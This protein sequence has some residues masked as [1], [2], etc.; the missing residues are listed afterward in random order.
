MT[1]ARSNATAPAAKGQ[2]VVGTGTDTSGVLSVGSNDQVL[3]A[4]SSTS[5]GVKWATASSGGMTV[6]GTTSLSGSSTTI[7]SIPST[8]KHLMILIERAYSV[9]P[10]Y[11]IA[12][13]FNSDSGANYNNKTLYGDSDASNYA[14]YRND[15][16]DSNNLEIRTRTIN[17]LTAGK[18]LNLVLNIYNYTSTSPRFLEGSAYSMNSGNTVFTTQTTGTY[19]G[20]SAISSITVYPS[21]GGTN[22]SGGTFTVYGVS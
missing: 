21:V 12:F 6:I 1:K 5:T 13:R 9:S 19:K 2:I 15:S 10:D 18:N 3:M 16:S 14:Y 11:P 17:T 20:S 8:Y 22:W 7:S 4:D